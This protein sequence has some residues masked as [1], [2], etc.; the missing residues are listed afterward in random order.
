MKR[1]LLPLAIGAA[2]AMPGLAFAEPTVYGKVNVSFENH[3]LDNG[4]DSADQWELNSNASRLGVKGSEK[5]SDNLSAVYKLEYEVAVDDGSD[6][7]KQRNIY[8][9]FKGGFGQ[10][11]VGKFDSPLKVAQGKVDQFNDMSDGDLKNV[12]TGENRE[13]N[14]IQYSTPNLGPV[15]A[16]LAIQPGE[17]RDEG[18]EDRVPRV[19]RVVEDAPDVIAQLHRGPARR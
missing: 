9:G 5:I 7:F 1:K 12:V 6:V 15:V 18:Q 17:D 11:I 14:L 8:G 2:V 19:L 10:I 4:D 3:D 16:T 13:S